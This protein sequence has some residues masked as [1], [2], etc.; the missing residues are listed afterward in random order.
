MNAHTVIGQTPIETGTWSI[1]IHGGAGGNVADWGEQKK[2]TRQRGMDVALNTG[3]KMLA[4]G[5]SAL[6]VVEAVISILEND[7][8]FNAGRGAVVNHLGKA[9]LD[10][11]LMNGADLRC[12][13]VAGVT[14]VKNPIALARHVM[15][16]TS[17]ILLVSDGAESFA[18]DCKV[19]QVRPEY[20]LGFHKRGH[21]RLDK[22][23][24]GLDSKEQHFGT[25]GCVARDQR[26]HLAA[27]TSTGG[28]RKKLAGRVGDSPL[29]GAGTYAD[30][31]YA[32]ISGTGIG[33]EYI[34]HAAAYD[35]IAQM[36]YGSKSL[37]D[38]VNEMIDHRLPNQSGGMIAVGK[39]GTIVMRHNTPSMTCGAASS[40]GRFEIRFDVPHSDNR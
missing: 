35:V 20:F 9:E 26:G 7:A 22:L 2:E 14:T 19:D 27:G 15:E 33:E 1:A 30:N 21:H 12:G 6:D 17:H 8:A 39:D 24:H 34:R 32:A 38:A 13:A 31:R 28:T 37:E 11:S 18:R 25:V 36:R 10:A 5:A 4:D 29:I 40:D 16:K 23:P 3:K